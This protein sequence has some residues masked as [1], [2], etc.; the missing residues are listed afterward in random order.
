VPRASK[1]APRCRQ[2]VSVSRRPVVHLRGWRS[3]SQEQ[4]VSPR[5]S[6]AGRPRLAIPL[7]NR[8]N[9]LERPAVVSGG[10]PFEA[11]KYRSA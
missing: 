4:V 5:A 10:S 3:G 11:R 2:F 7:R 6:Q 1:F 8:R 9:R